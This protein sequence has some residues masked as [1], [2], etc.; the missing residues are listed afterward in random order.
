MKEVCQAQRVRKMRMQETEKKKT[1]PVRVYRRAEQRAG[2]GDKKERRNTSSLSP[3]KV[4]DDNGNAPFAAP[5]QVT[6]PAGP[7]PP[8]SVRRCRSTR[9]AKPSSP[10][11]T[12]RL[13]VAATPVARPMCAATSPR[14]S[15]EGPQA[16]ELSPL[17]LSMPP[18]S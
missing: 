16:A 14:R 3:W 8:P 7:P 18:S 11:V 12:A 10:T 1:P 17:L 2:V 6:G 13:R 15:K 4:T 9:L 5:A